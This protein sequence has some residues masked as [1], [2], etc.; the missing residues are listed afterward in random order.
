MTLPKPL[1]LKSSSAAPDNASTRQLA[2]WRILIVDDDVEVHTVTRLILSKTL[3]KDR[4][5]ELLSA[6]SAA[7][8]QQILQRERDI[9]VILLDVVMETEDAGL[10]LVHTIRHE[11]DNKAV[12]IILRTGQPGQ[13]PEE[14]VI[15]DYDINDY[16]SKSELTAQK[17]FTT[18]IASLRTYETIILLEKTRLGLEKIIDCSDSL[19]QVNSIRE[20]ASGMLTQLSSFLDCKPEGILCIEGY[21]GVGASPDTDHSC[22]GLAVIAAAGRYNDCLTCSNPMDEVTCRHKDMVAHIQK[23]LREHKNQFDDDY[24]VLYLETGDHKAT[25]ALVHSGQ[26]VDEHDQRLLT[27]FA[28]KISIA[29]ANVIHYQKMVSFEEAATTD[30]LTGL[31][32]RRQL[33]RLGIPLLAGAQRS[34]TPLTVAMLDIDH[35]KHVNDTYGHDAGDVVLKHIGVLLRDRFRRSDIV[36]RY[37]GEEFCIL[38]PQLDPE[39]AFELFDEFR[40]ALARQTIKVQDHA[41]VIT[42]SIGVTTVLCDTLDEM[43]AKADDL[44]YSAKQAGRNR[45][46]ISS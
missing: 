23:A 32:N 5:V 25:I 36:A 27:L 7:E 34:G 20:F 19:F 29:L 10:Q 46:V 21:L 35:F 38:A 18:V 41:L 43:I 44:L 26:V 31:N 45:V 13:A 39:Q 40:Y 15:I 17:L 37:G 28:S 30:F 16:K 3:F 9:A 1:N 8:A 22:N 2:P 12:R 4:K 6:Y 33:L 14:R 42:V 11:L 24:T